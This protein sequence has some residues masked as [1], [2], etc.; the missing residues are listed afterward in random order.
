MRTPPLRHSW[1]AI[2]AI[3]A[4]CSPAA[5]QVPRQ[6]SHQGILT[7]GGGTPIPDGNYSLTV[8]LYDVS[9]GGSAVYTETHAAVPVVDGGFNLLI[10]SVTPLG[11]SFDDPLWLSL[12]VDA[13]P[14][15][16]PRVPF[17][18][19][20]YAMGL[21]LP[22][23]ATAN[24]FTPAFT[25]TNTAGTAL[26]ANGRVQVFNGLGTTPLAQVNAFGSIGGQLLTLDEAG[27]G[28]VRVE[29][30]GNGTG[31]Y[32]AVYRNGTSTGFTL[33]G[34]DGT[35]EPILS[36]TGS[37]RSVVMDMSQ[38]GDP[39]VLLPSGSVSS[40]EQ[41]NEPGVAQVFSNSA[42]PIGTG[43]TAITSRTIS[44]PDAG[45]V[46]AIA[47]GSCEF[48]HV[49]GAESR[50]LYGINDTAAFASSALTTGVPGGAPTGTYRSATP[51]VGVFPVSAGATTFNL[52]AQRI[53]AANGA[54]LNDPTI[55]L[56][57]VPTAYG[58]VTGNLTGDPDEQSAAAPLTEAA[59]RQE[60]AEAAAFDAARI[61][62]ELDALRRR[63][64]E[65]QGLLAADPNVAVAAQEAGAP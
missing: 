35:E 17:A 41:S 54:V 39:A 59:I 58:A 46:I 60:Q 34:N 23:E 21:S 6:I 2:P 49:N 25:V 45:H 9:T 16:S 22:L 1:L 38:S 43:V 65:I 44:A 52:L 32:F 55:T 30:D 7:D 19:A 48:G 64:D 61:R 28:T 10:G 51:W 15:M 53:G 11:I 12:Q 36:L 24:G 42:V 50:I 29:P 40:L 31:G 26:L 8:R 56:I 47:G 33:N 5:A 4:L 13:D 57:Y 14:E 20:P 62:D 63:M 3:L 27:Q 18:C 37:V